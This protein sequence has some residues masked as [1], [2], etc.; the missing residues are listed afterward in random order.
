MRPFVNFPKFVPPPP[1]K[2]IADAHDEERY[3]NVAVAAREWW[4]VPLAAEDTIGVL[5]ARVG[6]RLAAA[7]CGDGTGLSLRNAEGELLAV[8][9]DDLVVG[10]RGVTPVGAVALQRDGGRRSPSRVGIDEAARPR[11]FSTAS[12]AQMEVVEEYHRRWSDEKAGRVWDTRPVR[13]DTP[14]LLIHT[15]VVHATLALPAYARLCLAG[16]DRVFSPAAVTT[17]AVK[18]AMAEGDLLQAHRLLATGVLPLAEAQAALF[19]CD[20]LADVVYLER[21]LM[22]RVLDGWLDKP[23]DRTG[24]RL[25]HCAVRKDAASDGVAATTAL[26]LRHGAD[27]NAADHYAVAPL[28]MAAECGAAAAAAALLDAGADPNAR[29]DEG[30]TPLHAAARGGG[31]DALMLVQLLLERG[32]D[33]NTPNDMG[34]TPLRAAQVRTEPERAVVT[35]L[36]EVTSAR[37]DTVRT[38]A[39]CDD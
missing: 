21:L 9:E 38:V 25:L 6:G 18:A 37:N 10:E 24:M 33:P 16:S 8:E 30:C 7:G 17:D 29:D 3:V 35:A 11:G 22:S 26:L 15:A 1:A 14:R 39:L 32:A 2:P 13:Q 5:R 28:H 20:M 4:R 27:A 31:E 23:L 36:S 19:A 12:K 34:Q